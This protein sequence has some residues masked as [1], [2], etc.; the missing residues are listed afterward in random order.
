MMSAFADPNL[1]LRALDWM[2]ARAIRGNGLRSM[3]D[4]DLQLLAADV[5]ASESD[6]REMAAQI[7]GHSELTDQMMRARG[8][9]PAAV[10]RA[11]AEAVRDLEAT[12]ARCRDSG[13]CYREL[14][15]GSA[16]ARYHVFC[17]NAGT[18]D[19][20]VQAGG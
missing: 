2:R 17:P 6:L 12:C 14:A 5:G 8:L 1:F 16:G 7:G 20:L 10:R 13:R 15:A 3:S 9:D 11:S 18:L 4:A 19:D